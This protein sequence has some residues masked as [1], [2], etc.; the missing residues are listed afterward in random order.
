MSGTGRRELVNTRIL[1]L[2][3]FLATVGHAAA[4]PTILD[5]ASRSRVEDV[6]ISPDGRYLA[7]I[8]TQ[9][10]KGMAVV[11]D[12]QA[13]KDQVMRPVLAEPERFRMTWCHWP[14][15]TRLMCGFLGMVHD[16]FVYAVTRLV[17]V[18]ADGKNMRVLIQNS[19]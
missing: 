17:A 9:D 14:T 8:Q 10:G 3:M 5:F 19:G 1:A 13:G 12:R 15:N 11:S 4:P 18:D 16:R 2:G 6:S 7:L